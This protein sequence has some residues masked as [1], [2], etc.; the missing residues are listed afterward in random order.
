MTSKRGK[1]TEV[2]EI[3]WNDF[4]KVEM[5]VGRV[6]Q[7]DP[8]PEVHTPSYLLQIDFGEHG[9]VRQ[10]SA[11][12]AENYELAQLQ[13]RLVVAVTNFPTKQIGP[14][15]SEV[16]VLAAQDEGGELHLLAPDG[17]PELG[18]RIR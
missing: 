5:R 15:M 1:V 14:H 2:A 10:S 3:S 17:E 13:D 12:L 8:F 4:D 6:V 16:L 18:A 9:G 11:A 7:V